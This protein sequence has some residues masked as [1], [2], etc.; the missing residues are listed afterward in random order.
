MP[1]V[2][3]WTEIDA[4]ALVVLE[5]EAALEVD[6]TDPMADEDPE[7][8]VPVEEVDLDSGASDETVLDPE[9]VV[10]LGMASVVEDPVII[11]V[12]GDV[13]LAGGWWHSSH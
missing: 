5:E 7:D 9:S 11:A 8:F 6:D 2:W 13:V 3:R 10:W 4:P 12:E 1:C